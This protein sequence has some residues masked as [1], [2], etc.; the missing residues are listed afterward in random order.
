LRQTNQWYSGVLKAIG[1]GPVQIVEIVGDPGTGKTFL[2]AELTAEA[3]RRGLTVVSS[4]CTEHRRDVL[5][6]SL[7]DLVCTTVRAQGQLTPERPALPTSP[8]FPRH[9]PDIHTDE[10]RDLL[11]DT[12]RELLSVSPGNGTVLTIDDFH[13]ADPGSIDMF[14]QLI[15]RQLE[16]PLLVV[17]AQRPR[18]SS[19][20]LRG[21][22]AHGVELGGVR[23]SELGPLT[24]GE[25]AALLSLPEDSTCLAEIH[26][27]AGG[28]PLYLTALAGER[29]H[30]RIPEQTTT[31]LLDEIGRLGPCARQII[32]AAAV[33]G[34]GWDLEALSAVAQVKVERTRAVLIEL[35]ERDLLRPVGR[36]PTYAFRHPL[37]HRLMYSSTEAVWKVAAHRRARDFLL[38][39]GAPAA[40][41]AHHVE[42]SLAG[43][44]EDDLRLL[45]RA[46]EEALLSDPASAVRWLQAALGVVPGSDTERVRETMVLLSRA[47]G[48]A[49]RLRESRDLLQEVLRM[50]FE[51]S[52]GGTRAAAIGF[53][54]L[55]ECL[56]G[57]YA[58]ARALL[59]AELAVLCEDDPPPEAI[60][61]IIEHGLI[62][63][64]NG[65]DPACERLLMARTLARRLGDKV[66]E[67]GTFALGGLCDALDTNVEGA[68]GLLTA[69]AEIF[70][71]LPDTA[72]AVHPEYLGILAWAEGLIGRTGDAQRHFDRGMAI[73]RKRGHV[74]ILS[75]LLL[76]QAGIHLRLGRPGETRTVAAE[77]R[78]LAERIN[79]DHVR[80]LALALE[81]IGAAWTGDVRAARELSELA[82]DVLFRRRFR[83]SGYATMARATAAR[84][85]RDPLRCLMLLTDMGGPGLRDIPPVLRPSC[86]EML[87][88]SSL[89]LAGTGEQPP[90]PPDRTGGWAT[91][92]EADADAIGLPA[93]RAYALAARA[94]TLA[95]L[96][97]G[98]A[99]HPLYRRSARLFSM[100][101]MTHMQALTLMTHAA[102]VSGSEAD[103]IRMLAGDLAR[104]SG[105]CVVG[106][107]P[108][109]DQPVL[110]ITEI[111]TQRLSLLTSRERQIAEIAGNGKRTREIAEELSLSPRTVDVHLSRIYRKLEISSRTSLA[112]LMAGAQ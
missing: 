71:R 98:H 107:E 36:G 76:G 42:R 108:T 17:I 50:P 34:D 25:S 102:L 37:M 87:T 63:A 79:A 69:A 6:R 29:L 93:A 84:L 47:L 4:R 15:H 13:W 83:W 53:C 22:L 77:A 43:P 23:R 61:L 44:D 51:K 65:Q 67:A 88:G 85:A 16:G 8:R 75:V 30:G 20:R 19:A 74:H 106:P 92:A 95:L 64:I 38:R 58:E 33:L 73:A 82:E 72:L 80:G 5:V 49:G 96:G 55:V 27:E 70:D 12:V 40:S 105:A 10:G 110:R 21:A 89:A 7:A 2:L 81:S 3:A 60:T 78:E 9:W 100:T 35:N 104:R 109:P 31:L 46:A 28:V 86:Y 45:S 48:L 52:C 68:S 99:A 90:F 18:Q 97:Q 32:A 103:G 62:G 91:E 101:G 56:L 54:A 1:R 24:L 26:H 57:N 59:A 111:L 14:E 112:R 66:G 11:F 39:R 94:H 41:L